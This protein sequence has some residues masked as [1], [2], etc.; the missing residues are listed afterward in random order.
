VQSSRPEQDYHERTG[1]TV[2]LRQT[3]AADVPADE[4]LPECEE[5]GGADGAHGDV[6]P[7]KPAVGQ[8]LV[9]GREC[10][11]SDGLGQSGL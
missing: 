4:H 11:S 8:D 2:A 7:L 5:E 3:T 9:D 10:P 1:G 6:P